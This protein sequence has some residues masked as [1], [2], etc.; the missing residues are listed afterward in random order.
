MCRWPS[1]ATREALRCQQALRGTGGVS[2]SIS[3]YALCQ[4][5]RLKGVRMAGFFFFLNGGNNKGN[6]FPSAGVSSS[7]GST[8]S[9]CPSVSV[10]FQVPS[11]YAAPR[12][13]NP[14]VNLTPNRQTLVIKTVRSA[15]ARTHIHTHARAGPHGRNLSAALM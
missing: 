8:Q 4:A 11:T 9:G 7:V 5:P 12:N 3:K 14:F 10:S 15:S 2:L 13:L 1:R 6:C